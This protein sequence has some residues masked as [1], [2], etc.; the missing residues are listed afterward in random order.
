MEHVT[1]CYCFVKVK[2]KEIIYCKTCSGVEYSVPFQS[3]KISYN[4]SGMCLTR[5]W[6]LQN[7]WLLYCFY[8]DHFYKT[9]TNVFAI[10]SR[11]QYRTQLAL[12]IWNLELGYARNYR[13]IVTC[14]LPTK[15]DYNNYNKVFIWLLCAVL[16][17][18]HFFLTKTA[19]IWADSPPPTPCCS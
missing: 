16:P 17:Y 15:S 2:K 4:V 3:F 18:V 6:K 10:V 19:W 5:W 9:I 11:I 7:V 14:V 1:V 8:L 13:F 12:I